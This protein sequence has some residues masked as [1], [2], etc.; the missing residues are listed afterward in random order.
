[1]YWFILI[2]ILLIALC[3]AAF[4]FLLARGEKARDK[5]LSDMQAKTS[6]LLFPLKHYSVKGK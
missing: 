3:I 5:R 6:Y 4:P 1:M 2:V